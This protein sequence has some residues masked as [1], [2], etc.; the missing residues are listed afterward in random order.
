MICLEAIYQIGSKSLMYWVKNLP[1]SLYYL[2]FHKDLN[3]DHY[4]FFCILMLHTTNEE[5]EN[6][7]EHSINNEHQQDEE[8]KRLSL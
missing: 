7:D 2:E 5:D 6:L 3:L 8:M 1:L 4:C